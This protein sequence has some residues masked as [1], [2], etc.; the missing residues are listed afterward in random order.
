[1]SPGEKQR[2]DGPVTDRT[3]G[4]ISTLTLLFIGGHG[5]WVFIAEREWLW[6]QMIA[7]LL[8][9]GGALDLVRRWREI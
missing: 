9:V 2:L 4:V 7:L 5:V 3:W 8:G 6:L 1:M